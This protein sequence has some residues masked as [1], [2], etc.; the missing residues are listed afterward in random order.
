MPFVEEDEDTD[1]DDVLV[2]NH[3]EKTDHETN[4]D[5]AMI[6]MDGIEVYAVVSALTCATS[7]GCFD[8]FNMDDLGELYDNGSYFLIFANMLYF[9]TSAVSLMAGLH[10]TLIFSLITMYGRTAVGID[11]DDAFNNFFGN[12]G[13]L[14]YQAYQSFLASLY[15]FLIQMT[16]LISSRA[17]P[18]LRHV[19]FFVTSYASYVIYR[20]SQSVIKHASVLFEPPPKKI[21]GKRPSLSQAGTGLSTRQFGISY[22]EFSGQNPNIK[23]D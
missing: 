4:V 12:T 14:R 7:I 11:R 5:R 20:N 6:R 9:V 21:M 10:T 3:E 17:P 8:N 16:L 15:G 1:D 13:I 18:S 19:S 2:V 23:D 22:D